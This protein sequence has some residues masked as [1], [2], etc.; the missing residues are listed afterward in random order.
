[1]IYPLTEK[2]KE[3]VY[4]PMESLRR[5]PLIS[6]LFWRTGLM[7]RWCSGL[8]NITAKTDALFHG[9]GKHVQPT[10][11]NQNLLSVSSCRFDSGQRH[12]IDIY[13]P[14]IAGRFL[15]LTYSNTKGLSVTSAICLCLF[16]APLIHCFAV[17]NEYM[18]L[19]LLFIS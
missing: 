2:Q 16:Y 15:I 9:I 3:I 5:N 6:D 18:K 8:K 13:L 11:P 19:F 17:L 1:M 12:H 7:N 10:G 14:A 4:Y